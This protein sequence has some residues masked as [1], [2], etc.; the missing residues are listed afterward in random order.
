MSPTRRQQELLAKLWQF[1]Q[2]S[3]ISPSVAE[4]KEMMGVKSNQSVIDMLA[5]LEKDEWL[6]R[7]ARKARSLSLTVNARQHLMRVGAAQILNYYPYPAVESYNTGSVASEKTD[8]TQAEITKPQDNISIS[9]NA[10]KKSSILQQLSLF[11]HN[12][13]ERES[14]GTKNNASVSSFNTMAIQWAS[15]ILD[16]TSTSVVLYAKEFIGSTFQN[17]LL[18]F[19]ALRK[20]TEFSFPEIVTVVTFCL[21]FIKLFRFPRKGEHVSSY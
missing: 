15:Q 5:R 14:E 12:Y 4:V 8:A 7:D 9:L 19:I 1:E 6:T 16:A 20:F 11:N 13:G 10:E 21:L 3:H 2:E 18:Y 17:G